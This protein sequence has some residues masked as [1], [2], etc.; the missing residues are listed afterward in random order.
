MGVDINGVIFFKSRQRTRTI[1]ANLYIVKVCIFSDFPTKS[2]EPIRTTIAITTRSFSLIHVNEQDSIFCLA[3]TT[4]H[5]AKKF[6][7]YA[8]YT[9]HEVL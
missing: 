8:K 6:I 3:K 9:L 1:L 7:H 4:V 5:N 2:C